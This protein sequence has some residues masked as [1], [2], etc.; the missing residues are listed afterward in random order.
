MRLPVRFIVVSMMNRVA[1]ATFCCCALLCVIGA[2]YFSRGTHC[3]V[4][5]SARND[6]PFQPGYICYT[7]HE[8]APVDTD[9]VADARTCAH[10]ARPFATDGCEGGVSTG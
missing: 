8:T 7:N 10:Y 1:Y 2:L 9:T 3:G 6:F 5:V 4:A